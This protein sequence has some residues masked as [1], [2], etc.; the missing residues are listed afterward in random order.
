M[1]TAGVL[2]SSSQKGL[3]GRQPFLKCLGQK[4]QIKP[5]T[6]TRPFILSFFLLLLLLLF[7]F[8]IIPETVVGASN[9][10]AAGGLD[11]SVLGME[12]IS[13]DFL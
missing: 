3:W 2:C 7:F 5:E 1:G 4:F 10:A 11:H 13:R 6:K 9:L 12:I 8:L